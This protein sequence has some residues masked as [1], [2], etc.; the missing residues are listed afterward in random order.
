MEEKIL[1][2]KK[3]KRYM[4]YNDWTRSLETSIT[5]VK[6]SNDVSFHVIIQ[7]QNTQ[8][9][10]PEVIRLRRVPTFSTI[11]LK[12]H[13]VKLRTRPYDPFKV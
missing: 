5:I 3:F 2:K 12:M 13:G 6:F 1:D 7:T 8:S 4:T 9:L 10:R 11:G